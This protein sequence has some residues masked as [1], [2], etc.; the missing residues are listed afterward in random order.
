MLMD[1]IV[2]WLAPKSTPPA[3]STLWKPEPPKFDGRRFC[4]VD[5]KQYAKEDGQG[6]LVPVILFDPRTCGEA[7]IHIVFEKVLSPDEYE[8]SLD[9]LKVKYPVTP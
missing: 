7:R 2:Q 6:P 9:Q 8:M 1:W 5:A 3:E 4:W